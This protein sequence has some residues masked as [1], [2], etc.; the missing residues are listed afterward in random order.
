M[1]TITLTA[2]AQLR[3]GP[4]SSYAIA[5]SANSGT[6]ATVRW[7]E[8]SYYYAEFPS[9]KRCLY[10]EK[11]KTY[12]VPGTGTPTTF[13]PLNQ[14][15]YVVVVSTP[16]LGE[17]TTYA[18]LNAGLENG[19]EVQY[20][21]K[22]ISTQTDTYDFIEY[23]PYGSVNKYRAWYPDSSLQ[24]APTVITAQ[25]YKDNMDSLDVENNNKYQPVGNETKCSF[26]A[27][28]VM[29]K[30]N[31]LLPDFGCS[32][33]LGRLST[34]FSRWRIVDFQSAQQ[35]AN[36]GCPTIAIDSGHV[37][38]VRPHGNFIPT[39]RQEVYIS[40]AGAHC[41]KETT[42]NYGWSMDDT[43]RFNNIQFYSWYY[44]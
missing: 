12:L 36:N 39:T 42:L 17:G 40:Q 24:N 26:F 19:L 28:D 33:M 22:Q 41:Y 13:T 11:S 32:Y 38:V 10:V 44:T 29:K 4:G 43:E 31:T 37:A 3:Y 25:Q 9:P 30:C 18:S 27:Q 5:E 2:T 35:N 16:R 34:V 20:L 14:E 6:Y 1:A 21:G 23:K 15:K 8:G 7:Q